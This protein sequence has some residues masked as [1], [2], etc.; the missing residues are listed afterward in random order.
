MTWRPAGRSGATALVLPD[1]SPI[2]KYFQMLDCWLTGGVADVEAIRR[3][4]APETGLFCNGPRRP[5]AV[6]RPSRFPMEIHIVW[7]FC[8]GVQGA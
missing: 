7:D 4:V 5:G 8:M 6:K 3:R 1:L 2:W